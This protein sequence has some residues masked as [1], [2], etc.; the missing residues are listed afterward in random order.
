M[1]ASPR[2]VAVGES[3]VDLVRHT[4][5]DTIRPIPGGSPANVAIGSHRLGHPVT[6]ITCWGEDPPGALVREYLVGAG[7][8]VLRAPTESG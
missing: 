4:G 5:A 2:A 6:L 7:V 8:D 3:L 1:T